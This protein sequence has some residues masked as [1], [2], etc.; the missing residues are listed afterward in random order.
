MGSLQKWTKGRVR[1][2]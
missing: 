1:I 2:L